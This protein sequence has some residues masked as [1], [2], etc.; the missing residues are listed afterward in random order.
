MAIP[1]TTAKMHPKVVT[2]NIISPYHKRYEPRAFAWM[3]TGALLPFRNRGW[4]S[5]HNGSIFKT[6]ILEAH[7]L[8]EKVQISATLVCTYFW[9]IEEKNLSKHFGS[10]PLVRASKYAH[11]D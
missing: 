10:R 6:P 4:G 7:Y 9:V 3:Q 8:W 2:P 11:Y 1:G 5:R